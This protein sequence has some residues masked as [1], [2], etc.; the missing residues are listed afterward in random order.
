MTT[1]L[2]LANLTDIARTASVPA[3]GR[4]D[5]KAGIVHFGVGSAGSS[6]MGCVAPVSGGTMDD[7][8]WA[9]A[10]VPSATNSPAAKMMRAWRVRRA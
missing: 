5:L 3:Y 7:V 1:K 8:I 9:N 2:S 4:K 6:S 10:A